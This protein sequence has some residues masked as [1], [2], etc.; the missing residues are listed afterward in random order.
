MGGEDRP[1]DAPQVKGGGPGYVSRTGASTRIC[2]VHTKN[3]EPSIHEVTTSSLEQQFSN[4]TAHSRSIRLGSQKHQTLGS[5]PRWT[6][7]E[8]GGVTPLSALYQAL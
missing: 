3:S 6:E 2:L 7:S 1:T 4:G 5:C 8:S